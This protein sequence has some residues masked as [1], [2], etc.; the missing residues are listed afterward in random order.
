MRQGPT[1]SLSVPRLYR[2]RESILGSQCDFKSMLFLR[3][4][5]GYLSNTTPFCVWREEGKGGPCVLPN[6]LPSLTGSSRTQ[7]QRMH[8][9]CPTSACPQTL[10]IPCNCLLDTLI[11]YISKSITHLLQLA[12]RSIKILSSPRFT[13]CF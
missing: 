11:I 9:L 10:T 3:L 5:V 13:G 1:F 2:P 6:P 12:L 4:Q 7:P 8:R